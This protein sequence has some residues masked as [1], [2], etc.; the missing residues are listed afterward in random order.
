MTR[1]AFAGFSHETNTFSPLPTSYDVFTDKG[2][3]RG[4]LDAEGILEMRGKR[5]NNGF[6]GFFEV[7]GRE[8]FEVEPLMFA[9][10]TPSGPVEK[11]AFDRITDMI[12]DLL[13]EKGPFDGVYLALHGAMVIEGFEDGETETLRKVKAVVGDTPVVASLDLHGNITAESIELS[14]AMVGFRTYPHVDVYET[15]KRCAEVMV[16]LLDGKPLFKA[17][18]MLPFII[19]ISS[20]TTNAEPAHSLYGLLDELEKT[21]GV[22]SVTF[23]EGFPPADI[24]HAGPSVFAY[25]E[26]QELADSTVD[27]LYDAI[28]SHESEFK[29]NLVD[30]DTAV[31]KAMQHSENAQKPVILADVQ[32]NA[33]AGSTSDTPWILQALVA[34][35]ARGAALGLMYDPAAA[36][37]AH[38]AGE[39]SQI[40]VG[41]GGKLTPGQQPYEA[42][43]TVEKLADGAFP[44]TGPMGKGRM[45][46][47]GKMA[48][49]RIDDVRVV[50][51]SVRTQ[52]LDQAYFRQVGIEPSDMKILVLKSSNHYRADF[53][54]IS[55]EIIQVAAPAAM[56]DDPAEIP[57]KNLRPGVRLGGEG[58]EYQ[59]PA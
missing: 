4:L 21:P 9:S 18:R 25:A 13:E 43:F 3:G 12:C 58:P 55:S 2:A 38:K 16:H 46:D 23:M 47:L 27:K 20:M 17:F 35:G 6:S 50:V 31:K 37:E 8:G 52:A 57:Y 53:E 44:A 26:T 59:S 5:Y 33:G 11:E 22:V 40:S 48:L 51:S 49:L 30:V 45:T 28:L 36:E 41:L 34:Q 29:P 42:T 14:A 10:A 1:I 7:A 39:G 54:P 56:I 24:P 15:G 19:P 32:D